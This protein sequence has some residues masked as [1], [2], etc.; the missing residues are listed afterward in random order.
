[1][2]TKTLPLRSF[3]AAQP[4][5]A[6]QSSR[7]CSAPRVRPFLL[8][9]FSPPGC[10]GREITGPEKAEHREIRQALQLVAPGK[11]G[12]FQNLVPTQPI[13]CMVRGM[14]RI[15]ALPHPPPRVT[16]SLRSSHPHRDSEAPNP[17]KQRDRLSAKEG[18]WWSTGETDSFPFVCSQEGTNAL[19]AQRFDVTT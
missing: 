18:A 4:Q 17:G 8:P 13:G 6:Q 2:C 19:C 9:T 3:Q 10:H 11:G 5:G 14:L 1:M 16:K 15:P 7:P 12:P